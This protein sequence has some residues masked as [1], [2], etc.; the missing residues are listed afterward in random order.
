MSS[1]TSCLARLVTLVS[2]SM[3]RFDEFIKHHVDLLVNTVWIIFV[4]FIPSC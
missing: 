1:L 4:Y 2:A 3:F